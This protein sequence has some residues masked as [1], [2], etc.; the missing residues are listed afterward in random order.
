[1]SPVTIRHDIERTARADVHQRRYGQPDAIAA[2]YYQWLAQVEEL[3][4]EQMSSL[5]EV[6]AARRS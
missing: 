4:G 6:C 5:R 2:P 1:M 3:W